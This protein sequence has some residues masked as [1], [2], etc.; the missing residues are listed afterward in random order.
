MKGDTSQIFKTMIEINK[1][2]NK[3]MEQNEVKIEKLLK[4]YE[5]CLRSKDLIISELL[6][7]VK[8]PSVINKVT[9]IMKVSKAKQRLLY[10]K[11]AST[12]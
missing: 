4:I 7:H 3:K 11:K 9:H 2:I 8:S 1:E 12:E 6:P 10:I 5:E